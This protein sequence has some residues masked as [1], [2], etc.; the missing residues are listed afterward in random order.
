M[1]GGVA[2]M[3]AL[4]A[5]TFTGRSLDTSLG[6]CQFSTTV[7]G[8]EF[9]GTF[10]QCRVVKDPSCEDGQRLEYTRGRSRF[11]RKAFVTGSGY[12]CLPRVGAMPKLGGSSSWKG[13]K[14]GISV[15]FELSTT[16]ATDRT[17]SAGLRAEIEF[18]IDLRG[19]N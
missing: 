7:A 14:R 13:E 15:K 8:S 12:L 5:G 18:V 4:M 19:R 3:A 6:S 16:L 11:R 1:I 10:Y 17:V 2:I 9:S